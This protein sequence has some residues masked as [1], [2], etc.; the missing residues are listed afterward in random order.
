MPQDIFE[1]FRNSAGSR[2]GPLA[3]A[4]SVSYGVESG[5]NGSLGES[6]YTIEDGQRNAKREAHNVLV[7]TLGGDTDAIVQ[8]RVG[9]P[10]AEILA[11]AERRDALYLVIGG[12]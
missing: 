8:G 9:E 11:E 12:R 5:L 2:D 4:G 10:A 3:G 7:E 6:R 1:E